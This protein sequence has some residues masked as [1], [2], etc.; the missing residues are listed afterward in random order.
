M[1]DEAR[2]PAGQIRIL[3]L[4]DLSGV[5][6]EPW[7]AAGYDATIVDLQHPTGVT[8][9]RPND[10]WGLL[11]KVGAD[12]RM[13]PKSTNHRHGEI[14]TAGYHMVFAFPP[15]TDLAISGARWYRDKGLRALIDALEL[16]EA[17]RLVCEASG[18]PYMIENPVGQLSTYWRKPDHAFDPLDFGAYVL[19]GEQYTKRTHLWTG[20]GFVMPAKRPLPESDEPNPIHFA[21]PGPER[22][23]FRSLTPRGFAQAVFEANEPVVKRR[24][25]PSE[26]VA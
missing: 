8:E 1:T 10:G 21:P 13:W 7:L 5:M 15:C 9:Y 12:V 3:S 26:G 24:V 23:N 14:I 4:C 19:A 11:A 22:A 6:V 17:C 16:V 25:I 18:A 2:V 20:G